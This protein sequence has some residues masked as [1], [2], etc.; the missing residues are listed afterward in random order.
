[1]KSNNR[2]SALVSSQL[3]FFV[4]NDHPNFITFLE[5]YYEY[6][7]Q[8]TKVLHR[9]KNFIDYKDVDLTE[10]E[11]AEKLYSTF[12]R[13]IPASVQ[14]DKAILLKHIK[15]F[16]R[17]KGTEKSVRFLMNVMFNK[18][19]EFYY[20]KKDIIRASD[21][22]WFI[23]RSLRITDTQISNVAN[24]ELSALENFEGIEVRG[25]L[26]NTSALVERVDRFFE[27]GAQI[28]ELILSNID[29]QFVS[30][31]LVFGYFNDTEQLKYISANT[32]GGIVNTIT[33]T[34]PGSR[35]NVGD[36]LTFV[37]NTGSGAVATVD[38]VS[39]GNLAFISIVN[40]GAG[41]QAN[42]PLVITGGGGTG[43]NATLIEVLD[44]SS[45][46]P[47]TY[48]INY[49]TIQV[50]ADT[51]LNNAVYSNLNFSNINSTFAEALD[52]YEYANTGPA[53]TIL[54]NNPGV[55]YTSN[56]DFGIT[57]NTAIQNLGILG[58][59]LIVN[60]GQGY[61]IGDPIEFINVPGGYGTGA[62]AVVSNVNTS[63]SN[64]INQ[65]QFVEIPGHIIGGSGYSQTALPLAN[66]ISST[67][68][69]ADIRVTALL[70][71]GAQMVTSN[72][73]VGAIERVSILSRGTGYDEAPIID[74][75][76]FGDGKANAVATSIAGVFSYPGRYLNDDGHLSSFNFLQD[77]DY[78]QNFSYSIKVQE[79][80]ENYREVIKSLTHPAG[81]KMFGEYVY[82]DAPT[83]IVGYCAPCANSKTGII[84]VSSY[85]KTGNTININYPAHIANENDEIY[86]EFLSGGFDNVS[87]GLAIVTSTETNY[88][89]VEQYVNGA[90]NTTGN[91]SVG[92][93]IA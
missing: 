9:A 83:D 82:I 75:S 39:T 51:P 2:T 60:G 72:T 59:M 77:R 41:Y 49:N 58:R 38:R 23:Q 25:A 11:Y 34:N 35:Y 93:T 33:I 47:N 54:V 62:A 6:L 63:D 17:A 46:H 68:S 27:Q 22:K 44:D 56:P 3:P 85:T 61:E 70:G 10:D 37:S 16:Y 12:L 76:G 91:V 30:G 13:L 31:E 89:E 52:F 26:S 5:K 65:V 42:N 29:G 74:L 64:S 71:F 79:S 87:N 80:T 32:F 7:E 84:K 50:E 92:L 1:M 4:R 45:V 48:Q 40:G 15:D 53:F 21:G 18:E 36:P 24:T 67:G 55:G 66:V 90:Q 14:A 78:Y 28:D 8:N 69:G 81:T 86:L 88:I 57:A 19:I 43:A 73:S 20:P